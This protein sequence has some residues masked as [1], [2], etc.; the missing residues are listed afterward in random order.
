[1]TGASCMLLSFGAEDWNTGWIMNCYMV[2]SVVPQQD[3][4]ISMSFCFIAFEVEISEPLRRPPNNIWTELVSVFSL[5]L[6]PSSTPLSWQLSQSL[7]E[8]SVA[9]DGF[10]P[11]KRV[12]CNCCDPSKWFDSWR[13]QIIDPLEDVC[14]CENYGHNHAGMATDRARIILIKLLGHIK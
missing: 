3:V 10:S 2:W 5:S 9:E 8:Q 13:A 14:C 12:Y 4:V 6:S 11:K 1:M 7:A